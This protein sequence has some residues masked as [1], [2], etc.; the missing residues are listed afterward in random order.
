M[1]GGGQ[2]TFLGASAETT[3]GR[4]PFLLDPGLPGGPLTAETR[5]NAASRRIG[6]LAK[7]GRTLPNGRLDGLVEVRAGHRGLPGFVRAADALGLAGRRPGWSSP[8]ASPA[9]G[10]RAT[11]RSRPGPTSGWTGST[12]W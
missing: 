5:V 1:A 11:R 12:R 9:P 7:T 8:R 3:S 6:A 2:A 10:C 4:F